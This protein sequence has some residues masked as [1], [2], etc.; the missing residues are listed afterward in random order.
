[1]WFSLLFGV[2]KLINGALLDNMEGST[3]SINSLSSINGLSSTT[4]KV[5]CCPRIACP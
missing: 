2:P 4:K 1:M 3:L 5:G